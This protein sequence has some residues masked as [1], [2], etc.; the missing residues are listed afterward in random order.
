MLFSTK[1]QRRP[2]KHFLESP[3]AAVCLLVHLPHC[4]LH[5]PGDGLDMKSKV[6]TLGTFIARSCS[7]TLARLHLRTVRDSGC[8]FSLILQPVSQN[9]PLRSV[10]ENCSSGKT[11]ASRKGRRGHMWQGVGAPQAYL[12][13]SG[14]VIFS[15]F[16]NSSSV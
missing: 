12:W 16:S 10:S 1:V 6:S 8:A 2:L 14:T 9:H 4:R 5:S 7:I 3:F 13:I 11:R 15:N